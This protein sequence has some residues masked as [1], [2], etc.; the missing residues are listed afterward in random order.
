MFRTPREVHN[1]FIQKPPLHL[2][3]HNISHK[4][5]TLI[6][7]IPVPCNLDGV[8]L[9]QHGIKDRLLR[10]PRREFLKSRL[11]NQIK[12]RLPTGRYSVITTSI[13]NLEDNLSSSAP[14][15]RL[16]SSPV[17]GMVRAIFAGE[18]ARA[19]KF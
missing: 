8:L 15:V 17:A 12:L 3:T 2:E 1:V 19:H 4:A 11:A 10:K 16:G 18:G 5:G 7:R 14:R 9:T 6:F 13:R